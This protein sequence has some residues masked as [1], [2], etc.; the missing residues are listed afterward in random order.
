MGGLWEGR[1][2]GGAYVGG[3]NGREEGRTLEW[4]LIVGHAHMCLPTSLPFRTQAPTR[5]DRSVG[6]AV[7]CTYVTPGIS[8]VSSIDTDGGPRSS[9]AREVLGGSSCFIP[10]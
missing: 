10:N 7:P 4:V 5:G 3:M 6:I 1:H 2:G 8:K 9:P